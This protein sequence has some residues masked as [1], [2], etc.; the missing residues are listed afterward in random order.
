MDALFCEIDSIAAKVA[1]VRL[2]APKSG[3]E[4]RLF[5]LHTEARKRLKDYYLSKQRIRG[6]Y[7]AL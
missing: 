2:E 1:K 6:L 5:A 7:E 4:I 3:R